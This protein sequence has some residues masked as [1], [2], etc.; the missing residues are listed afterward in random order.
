MDA[1]SP[2]RPQLLVRFAAVHMEKDREY[3][4]CKVLILATGGAS[5]PRTGST[6]EGYGL[7]QA[8]HFA[9]SMWAEADKTSGPDRPKWV[10][11][12]SPCS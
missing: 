6:G 11:S 4:E 1:I 2:S 5:Y 12:S 8:V 7:A 9:K 10:N 3:R